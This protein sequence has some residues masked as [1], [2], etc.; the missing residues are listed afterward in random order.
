MVLS[1]R[2]KRDEQKEKEMP[3]QVALATNTKE[4]IK[5]QF[6]FML[7]MIQCGRLE[8]AQNAFERGIALVDDA[9]IVEETA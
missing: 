5:F 6:N 8:E 3:K 9:N 7:M 1:S 2:C 4:K